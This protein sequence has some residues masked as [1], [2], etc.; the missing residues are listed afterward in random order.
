MRI[1]QV[2]LHNARLDRISSAPGTSAAW[3]P[4]G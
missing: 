3:R 1:T 2:A 4:V